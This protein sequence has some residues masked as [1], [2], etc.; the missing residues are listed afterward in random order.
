MT[1]IVIIVLL[2]CIGLGCAVYV[3]NSK[4][5]RL[6][7]ELDRNI[8][9]MQSDLGSIVYHT[10][11]MW[12]QMETLNIGWDNMFEVQNHVNDGVETIAQEFIDYKRKTIG[13]ADVDE[14]ARLKTAVFGEV[15]YGDKKDA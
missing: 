11:E 15:N 7:E 1:A 5:D 12:H 13:T 4:L 3:L 8:K 14:F 6:T 10:N 9:C 2:M